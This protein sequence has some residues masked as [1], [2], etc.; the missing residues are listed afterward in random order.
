[1]SKS[2]VLYKYKALRQDGVAISGTLPA[3]DTNH[4][5]W[6]LKNVKRELISCKEIRPSPLSKLKFSRIGIRQKVQL[7]LAYLQM[8]RAGVPLLECIDLSRRSIVDPK[9]QDVM[10][11][12]YRRIEEGS[13]LSEALEH[14]SHIFT[15]TEKAIIQSKEETGDL[16]N[17]FEFLIKYLTRKDDLNRQIKKVTRYPL[18]LFIVICGTVAAMLTFVVPDILSFVSTIQPA[19]E[20][21]AATTSLMATS[22]FLQAYFIHLFLGIV[23]AFVFIKI[24]YRSSE[25][26]AFMID[27]MVINLPYIGG[28]I[29]K[30][31]IS[32]FC[33]SFS[34][35]YSSGISVLK[36]CDIAG[37]VVSNRVMIASVESAKGQISEGKTITESFE[38]TGEFSDIV[39]QMLRIGEESGNLSQGLDQVVDF[40]TKDVEDAIG[41]MVS[42]IEPLLTM[43]L[44]LVIVW[45]AAAVFGPIYDMF[46]DMEF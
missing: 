39:I 44:A 6:Q 10:N 11:D 40:Y 32:N 5:Y 26:F 24:M 8:F 14:H 41:A 13:T 22:E 12:I 36:S 28:I 38:Y 45:I 19:E 34:A 9:L 27:R 15:K 2:T 20:M 46:E 29:K 35:L 7:Y 33:T 43:V 21:S 25:V 30:I 42:M 4:L 18:I 23:G 37:D 17:A 1:M 16:D 3:Y 31:E